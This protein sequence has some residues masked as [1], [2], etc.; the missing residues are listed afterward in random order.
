MDVRY[1]LNLHDNYMIETSIRWEYDISYLHTVSGGKV[2][3]RHVFE[4]IA[5][6][7]ALLPFKGH[8][9]HFHIW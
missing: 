7:E 2:Y 8:S 1:L 4:N 6:C 5:I 3:T 9:F